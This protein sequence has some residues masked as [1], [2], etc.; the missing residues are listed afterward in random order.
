MTVEA[1]RQSIIAE[2]ADVLSIFPGQQIPEPTSEVLEQAGQIATGTVFFFQTTPVQVGLT[3]IDWSGGHV[4]HQEWRAM[5]NR[6]FHLGPLASAY[7][8]TADER[9]ARAA[10]AYIEDWLNQ[11]GSCETGDKTRVG[12]N[13]LSMSIRLGTSMHFGWSGLLPVFMESAAFDDAFLDRVLSSISTQARFLSC[14]LTK[15]GNWRISEL[16]ALVFVALRFPFLENA[17]ELLRV[18]IAGIRNALATQFLPDGV[19]IERTPGYAFWMTRVALNYHRLVKLFPEAD[20]G[21][22]PALIAKAFDYRVQSVLS[23]F[24]DSNV[25]WKDPVE[26]PE[27]DERCAALRHLL[28]E[29]A[30]ELPPLEQVF[31]CAGQVFVRSAW[32][33]G[34][35]YL[36]F[37][38]STWGGG[39]THLSRLGFTFRSGGRL[40]IADPG[41]F[42]YEMTDPFGPY[43]KS[44]PAHSTLNVNGWNQS[45]TD[46]KLLRTEFT[47]ETV[48]IHAEYAGGYWPGTHYWGFEKHGRGTFGRHERIVFQVRGQYM[49]VLDTM[50]C[51]PGTTV[52]NCWQMGPMDG[53][54]SDPRA[55]SWWSTNDDVN[56]LVKMVMPPTGTEM[57]CFEGSENPL[58]GWVGHHSHKAA[59]AP[60]V[61]FRCP[62]APVYWK[63]GVISAMLIAPFTG[64]DVPDYRVAEI[65]G[66][67]DK[68]LHTV[69]LTLP[70]GSR[71]SITWTRKLEIPIEEPEHL[72]TDALFVWL[73]SDSDGRPAKCFLLNGSYLKHKGQLLF[74]DDEQRSGLVNLTATE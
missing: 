72:T 64:A 33:P 35:D 70:D 36:A 26:L 37:D 14:H 13:T 66:A 3:N 46:A 39:H 51:D 7:Q 8:H 28:P 52:H 49:L 21:V 24:N 42:T 17:D 38:A 25:T 60:Q 41:K 63:H 54:K 59:P 73:R 20:V 19:H 5:L 48:L 50:E 45:D 53:W 34:S 22:D 30:D 27:L 29:K 4:H 23:G 61:E 9:F 69:E 16:D 12:D 65:R 15:W 67:E 44:T 56:V 1:D 10:R 40:L 18:G 71:D 55:L 47:T 31:P 58:R 68:Y 6:F 43:G 62:A 32:Q 11:G 57:E 74:Q 2:R